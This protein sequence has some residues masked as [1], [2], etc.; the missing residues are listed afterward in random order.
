MDEAAAWVFK[1]SLFLFP[2]LFRR[3]IGEF[4]ED[5]IKILL[6]VVSDQ[7]RNRRSAPVS[8]LQQRF[9]GIDPQA[10]QVIDVFHPGLFFEQGRQ[11]G[12]VDIENIRQEIQRDRIGI[13]NV[14]IVLDVDDDILGRIQ[15]LL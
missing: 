3:Q 14:Q 15:V 13:M 8:R 12:T 11:I 7:P 10:V 1:H 5:A 9:G 4:L 2:V 6:V